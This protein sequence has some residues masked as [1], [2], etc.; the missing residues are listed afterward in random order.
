MSITS[1]RRKRIPVIVI[2]MI[3]L[4][5]AGCAAFYFFGTGSNTSGGS[6]VIN[7]VLCSNSASFKAYDGRF[8]DWIELY[9]PSS[10]ELSLD[11][12]YISDDPESCRSGQRTEDPH[13]KCTAGRL[14][15]CGSHTSS[16]R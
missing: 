1:E 8:Y 2:L 7:E 6:P 12:Y 9:N 13:L 15:S 11:G 3:I 16:L 14:I 5:L 10:S 4:T